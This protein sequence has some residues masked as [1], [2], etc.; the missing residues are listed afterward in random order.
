[1]FEMFVSK[2]ETFYVLRMERD[3]SISDNAELAR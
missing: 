3:H 2:G 1:M